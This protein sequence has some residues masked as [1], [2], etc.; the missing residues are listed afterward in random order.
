MTIKDSIRT[1]AERG[2]VL[3]LGEEPGTVHCRCSPGCKPT[4][5]LLAWIE[6]HK[7]ALLVEL[8]RQAPPTHD[9][10][11]IAM[12]ALAKLEPDAPTR[13]R[14]MADAERQER[15]WA[16]LRNHGFPPGWFFLTHTDAW[17]RLHHGKGI[18]VEGVG[19][20]IDR[21]WLT[22]APAEPSAASDA[23]SESGFGDVT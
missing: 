20:G 4:P 13:A 19:D 5:Q 10:R 22:D 6:R 1:I 16:F 14:V 18:A 15:G 9:R 11:R 7:S 23:G 2:V 21:W 3:S 8:R 17:L 12:A